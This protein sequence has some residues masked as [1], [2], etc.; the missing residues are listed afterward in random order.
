MPE[1]LYDDWSNSLRTELRFLYL[2]VLLKQVEGF[3]LQ[4]KV[5]HAIQVC[6]RYLALE[7][8]DEQVSRT[9]M[10]LLWQSEQKKLALSLYHE[11]VNNLI[12]EYDILPSA[13][14]TRLYDQIRCE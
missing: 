14:T 7:P 4:G 1:N 6:R 2:Q 8:A 10:E 5:A 11:L 13:E 12:T 3:T 9:V